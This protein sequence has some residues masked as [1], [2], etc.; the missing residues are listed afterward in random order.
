[1]EQVRRAFASY[2]WD[3]LPIEILSIALSSHGWYLAESPAGS[4]A[5]ES[6]PLVLVYN[7]HSAV[8]IEIVR[9]ARTEHPNGGIVLVTG[10]L[11]ESEL[12][13]FIEAGVSAYVGTHESFAELLEAM[14]MTLENCSRSSGRVMR[15]V[16]EN[17]SRLAE[18]GRSSDPM[19]LTFREQEIL[20]LVSRGFSNKEI[21]SQLSIAPNTVKHHV[22][23]VLDKLRVKNRHQAASVDLHRLPRKTIS[24]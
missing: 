10:A 14:R 23:N 12:L 7:P 9:R 1:M 6:L 22:H 8:N 20:A 16:V 4:A 19:R 13:L 2:G 24:S 18:L 15:L 17:I 5:S 11:S 21:A 3:L